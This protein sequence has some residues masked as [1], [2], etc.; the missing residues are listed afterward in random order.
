MVDPTTPPTGT[1]DSAQA[2]DPAEAED[3]GPLLRPATFQ[4]DDDPRFTWWL[5]IP[6]IALA[7][8]WAAWQATSAD[9]DAGGT[10][11]RTLLW[12]GAGLFVGGLGSAFLG[13]RLDID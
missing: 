10:F 4:D 1:E 7:I 13:W 6:G 2:A 12:P 5:P 11:L 8:V 9:V 3:R